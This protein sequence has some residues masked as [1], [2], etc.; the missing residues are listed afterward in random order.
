MH[1]S[2]KLRPIY[3]AVLAAS[4][5]LL[6]ACAGVSSSSKASATP[7][8]SPGSGPDSVALAWN[9]SSSSVV[10]YNVY[11]GTQSG[12][13][14]AKLNSSVLSDTTY[15]DSNTESGTTYYYVSTAVN[16]A[17]QESTYSNEASASIP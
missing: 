14:Y 15:T 16:A 17:N 9:P 11:R 12:G 13:P 1:C 4:L 6:S 10:G 3:L 8:P 5:A 2:S 7:V